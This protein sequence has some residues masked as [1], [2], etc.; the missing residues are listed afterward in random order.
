MQDPEIIQWCK[1][2]GR[3]WVTHDF[4]AKR[5]HGEAMKAAR[6]HVVWIRG[7]PEEGATWLFFKIIVRTIDEIGRIIES[8]HGAIHFRVSTGVGSRPTVDWAESPYDW[9]RSYKK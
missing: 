9:P 1:D 4:E 2:N 6:I 5:K 3:T 7:K 8:S